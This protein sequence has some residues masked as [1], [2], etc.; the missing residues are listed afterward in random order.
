MIPGTK[1]NSPEFMLF[2]NQTATIR[3]ELLWGMIT[4]TLPG[5]GA[6]SSSWLYTNFTTVPEFLE[7]IDHLAFHGQ[8]PPAE[9]AAILAYCQQ[10]SQTD[11]PTQ[12]QSALFLALNSDSFVVS[13]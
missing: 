12:L 4:N 11:M 2:N 10:L 9:K 8:M 7:A 13:H 6:N 5:Y 1:I 3:S